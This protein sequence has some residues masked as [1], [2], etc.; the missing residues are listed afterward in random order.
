MDNRNL[1]MICDD[2]NSNN[3]END[4]KKWFTDIITEYQLVNSI[5]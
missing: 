5:S 3:N 4:D 1:I 2:D